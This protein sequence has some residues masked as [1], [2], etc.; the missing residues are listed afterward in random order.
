ME[1]TLDKKNE[2]EGLIKIKLNEGDYRPHVEE[3]VKDYAKKAQIKGFRQGKVPSGVIRKMFGKSILVDEINHLL[4]HKLSDY[5]KDNKLKILG[6]PIP[7][8]EKATTIDWDSQ[9]DFEFEYQ[10]GLVEEFSYELSP[11]VKVTEYEIKVNDAVIEETIT[12]LRKRFGKVSYPDTIEIND[13]LFGDVRAKDGD[14]RREHAY[15]DTGKIEKSTQAQFSGIKKE[16]EVEFDIEKLFAS[17]EDRDQFLGESAPKKGTFIIK[18]QSI[19]RTEPAEVNQE[20]FDRVFGKDAAKTEDEFRNKVVETIG[21]NYRRET[22]HFT[23]HQIEDALLERTKINL[24]DEFLKTWLKISG[25]GEVTDQVIDR[26]FNQYVRGLKW[27]LIK[28]RIADDHQIKVEGEE[29]RNKA[30]EM[31]TAQFGGTA[32]AEEY[33]DKLDGIADNYLSNENGQNFVRLY[34][35]LK[36]ERVMQLIREKIS[37][38]QKTVTVDEFKEIVGSHKH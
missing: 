12:D 2:T 17:E 1:I 29:V 19:T 37:I 16:D 32:F 30:K 7:N 36:N 15:L 21:D 20:L 24:P 4:S 5:I 28:N 6:E 26:E 8:Q 25:N 9:K 22:S 23:E 33:A 31:I 34:N 18:V 13:F 27:D 35:Q 11:K 38:G 3:K 10:V 14:F